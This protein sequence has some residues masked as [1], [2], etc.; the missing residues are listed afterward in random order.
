ML[1]RHDGSFQVGL[2]PRDAVVLPG[3]PAVAACLARLD[4][5]PATGDDPT[6]AV[7]DRA[8]LLVDERALIPLVSAAGGAVEAASA[9]AMVR[10]HG[11][12]AAELTTARAARPVEVAGFGHPCGATLVDRARELLAGAGLGPDDGDTAV[13]VLVGVGEPER[14]RTDRWLRDQVPHLPVGALALGLA[15]PDQDADRGVAVVRAESRPGE[16]L[17]GPVDERGSARVPEPRHLHRP[18]TRRGRMRCSLP[19]RRRRRDR[20]STGPAAPSRVGGGGDGNGG[21]TPGSWWHRP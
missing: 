5:S 4:G 17:A 10:R 16:Q 14:E 8:G 12:R 9:A 13:A 1:R 20:S 18:G 19:D 2:D 6:L 21:A 3:T 15:D 11:A 7:L